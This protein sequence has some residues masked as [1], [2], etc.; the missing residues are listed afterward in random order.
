MMTCISGSEYTNRKDFSDLFQ[1]FKNFEKLKTKN[2]RLSIQYELHQHRKHV[3]I[4]NDTKIYENVYHY[5][6]VDI[7][8]KLNKKKLL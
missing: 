8:K 3:L 1:K 6:I 5:Q 4:I 7:I 2:K